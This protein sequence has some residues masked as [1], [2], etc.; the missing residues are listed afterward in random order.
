MQSNH[1][2]A[3]RISLQIQL[4]AKNEKFDY[5]IEHE[6]D[7]ESAKM[8]YREIR[9]LRSRLKQISQIDEFESGSL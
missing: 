6:E 1:L 2:H 7:C 9:E 5:A 4:Q 8:L 3:E